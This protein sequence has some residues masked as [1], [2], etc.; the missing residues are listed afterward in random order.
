LS[1]YNKRSSR[2][3]SKP[4]GEL[5]FSQLDCRASNT[6]ESYEKSC[7]TLLNGINT[8]YDMETLASRLA[9]PYL[10]SG[11]ENT[12]RASLEGYHLGTLGRKTGIY[13]PEDNV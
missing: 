5:S 3:H 2:E 9:V 6:T 1:E 4:E 7:S 8:S 13:A 12:R 11:K 10:M